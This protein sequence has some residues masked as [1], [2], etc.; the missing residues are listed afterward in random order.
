M[1]IPR[2]IYYELANGNVIVDTGER[3]GDVVET[4]TEQDFASYAALAARI[5]EAVGFLQLEYGQ[6]AEDFATCN[7]YRID[8][9]TEKVLFSYPDSTEPGLP[10]VYQRPLSETV[11]AMET[12]NTALKLALAE[13]AETQEADKLATQIALAELAEL[14]A[15]GE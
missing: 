7:G 4:T 8:P 12:E 2:K 6:Y 14:V 3:S 9:D 1:N 13:L 15:G 11:A 10:P 5:P